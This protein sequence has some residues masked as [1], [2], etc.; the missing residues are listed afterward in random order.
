[1]LQ[2]QQGKR[3]KQNP[4]ANGEKGSPEKDVP[5]GDRTTASAT[6]TRGKRFLGSWGSLDLGLCLRERREKRDPERTSGLR[7]IWST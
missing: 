1:M 4:R 2:N 3:Q 7:I 6:E 5:V